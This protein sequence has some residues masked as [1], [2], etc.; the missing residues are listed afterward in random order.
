MK[1][2][3]YQKR[4]GTATST[5]L[6]GSDQGVEEGYCFGPRTNLYLPT[7]VAGFLTP[8]LLGPIIQSFHHEFDLVGEKR[9]PD[10]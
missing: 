6:G 3:E 9:H 5:A 1:E 2:A 10:Q 7:C 8:S 4:Q